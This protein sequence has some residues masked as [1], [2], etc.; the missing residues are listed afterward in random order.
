MDYWESGQDLNP[1]ADMYESFKKYQSQLLKVYDQLALEYGFHV[2][3]AR[4]SVQ[5]TQRML[6]DSI[7]QY[8]FEKP[9]QPVAR[10]PRVRTRR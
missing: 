10:R 4:H 1:H 2:L 5:H 8:L 6:Q 3:N 9:K 7:K